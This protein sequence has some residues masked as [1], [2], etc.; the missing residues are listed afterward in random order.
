MEEREKNLGEPYFAF[1]EVLANFPGICNLIDQ[2]QEIKKVDNHLI[3]FSSTEKH[4]RQS[5]NKQTHV[6]G[7]IKQCL[8]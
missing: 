5:V 8:V 1:Q 7:R 6:W 4:T 3:L 2:C